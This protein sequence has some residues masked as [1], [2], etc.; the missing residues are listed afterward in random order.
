MEMFGRKRPM[1]ISAFLFNIGAILMTVT[2]HNLAMI[3]AGRAITGFAVGILTATIP[4]FISEFAP[5]AIRGQ[6]TGFFEIAYQ[7]GS[8]V[9]FWINYGI[10]SHMDV[11]SNTSWRVAMAVQLIPGGM[12]AIGS[13]VLKESPGW[14]LRK[15]R[16]EQALQVLS[17]I[18]K[19]P[20]NHS[21]IL[22]EVAL[23]QMIIDEERR[24]AGDKPGLWNYFRGAVLQLQ[25]PDVRHRLICLWWMF[26]LMNF[27]GE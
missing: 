13:V 9:G 20:E 26:I 22:E 24:I 16:H 27:S 19:L 1:Q 7:A 23:F 2:T 6:L 4:T 5:P 15:G 8:L 14:L 18:R 21:Y 10:S 17:Y 12:L 3:Y 11:N 25:V